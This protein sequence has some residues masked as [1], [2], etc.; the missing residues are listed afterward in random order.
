M[1]DVGIPLQYI[2]SDYMYSMYIVYD[3]HYNNNN[4]KFLLSAFKSTAHTMRCEL[5]RR[6]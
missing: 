5:Q 6:F 2:T 4:K 3:A 1:W